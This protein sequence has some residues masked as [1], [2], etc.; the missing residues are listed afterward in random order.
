MSEQSAFDPNQ[1][2]GAA[3]I[4]LA[5]RAKMSDDESLTVHQMHSSLAAGE[6]P[7]AVKRDFN[8]G[9]EAQVKE[10]LQNVEGRIQLDQDLRAQDKQKHADNEKAAREKRQAI[11]D[12]KMHAELQEVGQQTAD[13]EE[14]ITAAGAEEK[15]AAAGG[16]KVNQHYA[17]QEFEQEARKNAQAAGDQAAAARREAIEA[18]GGAATIGVMKREEAVQ[19]EKDAFKLR[20]HGEPRE[21]TPKAEKEL[22]DW[23]KLER[24]E[25]TPYKEWLG[26]SRE[27]RA[28]AVSIADAAAA[29][30]NVL[31]LGVDEDIAGLS[32]E[33][34]RPKL[35]DQDAPQD[36]VE[37]LPWPLWTSED[38]EDE[39]D[40]SF[41]SG[42]ER[43]SDD[44]DD[45]AAAAVVEEVNQGRRPSRLLEA[46]TRATNWV[47]EKYEDKF[48]RDSNEKAGRN[49]RIAIVGALVLGAGAGAAYLAYKGISSGGSGGGRSQ[50][51]GDL[52]P[53]APG[54]SS[55]GSGAET[56]TAAGQFSVEQGNGFTHEIMD[57]ANANGKT[58]SPTR[59][60]EI[61]Q[62]LHEQFGDKLIDG[63]TTYNLPNGDL[64]IA[65]P[66]TNVNWLPG[67]R[68]AI[69]EALKESA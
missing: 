38:Y 27:A 22:P 49:R 61:Y 31:G 12:D 65:N 56:A 42:W 63:V 2:A 40:E 46:Y 41:L 6:L 45:A 43:H 18:N 33:E 13:A 52:L 68:E 3:D 5:G 64:G 51:A 25:D 24:P 23:A 26:M 10:S 67:V 36:E 4:Q 34:A 19:A 28:N 55:P 32:S 20:I 44:G 16:D 48:D 8:K 37:E 57:L 60:Y 9:R 11:L 35:F 62:Q 69:E 58:I 29:A 7:E 59:S 1:I 50:E 21:S 14:K 30:K 53:Q 17:R 39:N 66:A 54:S 47:R 15:I